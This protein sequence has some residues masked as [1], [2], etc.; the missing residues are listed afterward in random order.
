M[1]KNI[2]GHKKYINIKSLTLEKLLKLNINW[3]LTL[4]INKNK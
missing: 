1:V 2:F 4:S 3:S